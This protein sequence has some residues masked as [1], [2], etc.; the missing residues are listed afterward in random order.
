M[1]DQDPLKSSQKAINEKSEKKG[2]PILSAAT[3]LIIYG[4]K[5]I[6]DYNKKFFKLNEEV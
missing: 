5:D 4:P 1:S 6:P 2:H 3:N